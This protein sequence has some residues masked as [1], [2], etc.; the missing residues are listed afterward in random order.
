[1]GV[2]LQVGALNLSFDPTNIN[3]GDQ[4]NDDAFPAT[5]VSGTSMDAGVGLY[6]THPQYYGGYLS[7]IFLLQLF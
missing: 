6:Y 2:G 1:M 7:L 4:T 3:L 5:S